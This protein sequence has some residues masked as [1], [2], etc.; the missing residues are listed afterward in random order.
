MSHRFALR[1]AVS[2]A[3]A[4]YAATA[5]APVL[6]QSGD[7]LP[8]VT[9]RLADINFNSREGA[10]LALRRIT[11]AASGVCGGEP[12]SLDLSRHHVFTQCRSESVRRAVELINQPLLSRL[13]P[14]TGASSN[15]YA[16]R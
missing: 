6:A 1:A 12:S 2:A 14:H 13:V 11:N 5:A 15:L 8:T 4:I 3:M 10:D 7:D 9:V 16:T